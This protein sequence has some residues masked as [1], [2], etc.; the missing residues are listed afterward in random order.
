MYTVH[1]FCRVRPDAI[2]E[3]LRRASQRLNVAL[4]G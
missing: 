1:V 3:F 4:A 2:D